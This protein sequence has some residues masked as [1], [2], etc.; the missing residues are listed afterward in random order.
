MPRGFSLTETWDLDVGNNTGLVV[1][2]GVDFARGA[3]GVRMS[4]QRGSWRYDKIYGPDYDGDILG[5]YFSEGVSKAI[6]AQ[7]ASKTLSIAPV[8]MS[9]LTVF[10]DESGRFR[11]VTYDPVFTVEGGEVAASVTIQ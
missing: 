2:D 7:E 10:T 6:L 1:G 8:P 9:S 11:E 3:L 5:R 4:V